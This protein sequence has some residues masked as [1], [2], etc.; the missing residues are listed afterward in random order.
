M[1]S[2]TRIKSAATVE[3]TSGTISSAFVE[4]AAG[5]RPVQEDVGRYQYFVT[6]VEA[7]GGRICMW[8]GEDYAQARADAGECAKSFDGHIYDLTGRQA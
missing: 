6:V 4:D 5:R 8:S 3:I 1:S 2:V 7:D